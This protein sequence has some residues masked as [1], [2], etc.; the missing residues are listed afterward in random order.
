MAKD[1]GDDAYIIHAISDIIVTRSIMTISDMKAALAK[2]GFAENYIEGIFHKY[3]L[4]SQINLADMDALFSSNKTVM[5][6]SIA[7]TYP[8]YD[9]R[10]VPSK[11]GNNLLINE[12][13]H[14]IENLLMDATNE[15]IIISPFV[16]DNGMDLFGKILKRKLQAGVKVDIV[17]REH[18]EEPL[19]IINLIKWI[20]DNVGDHDGLGLYDYHYTFKGRI[21]STCHAKIISVD[22]C[23]SYVGSADIRKRS[24]ELNFE[25]GTINRGYIGMCVSKISREVVNVSRKIVL[26]HHA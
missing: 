18:F 8:A 1:I 19:R 11:I 9:N 4:K 12:M 21:E 10:G 15:I 3:N 13:R 20:K 23:I 17:M 5:P 6:T 14:E 7:V 24:F 16:E 2:Y 22:K 26:E 25:M